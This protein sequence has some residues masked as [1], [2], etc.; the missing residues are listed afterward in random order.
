[1]KQNVLSPGNL[2][3]AEGVLSE[4]GYSTQLVKNY[5]RKEIKASKFR[6]KEW[7]YYLFYNQS[8]GIALTMADNSYLGL[9]S[10]TVLDFENQR[11]TTVSPMKLLTLGK[12]KFPSSSQEGDLHFQNNK[13]EI[14]FYHEENGRR[15]FL[16]LKDFEADQPLIVDVLLSNEPEDSM[17]IATPFSEDEKAFYYNQKIVGMKAQGVVIY[18]GN[19]MKFDSD[20]THAILDWGRG[21]W[22]YENT[23]YWSAATGSIDGHSFGF[24]LGYGFGNTENATENM[25]FYDGKAHKLEHVTFEIPNKDDGTEDYMKTWRFTSSDGRFEAVF[26]PILDRKSFTSLKIISSDQHQ[27]FGYFTGTA[28]LDDGTKVHLNDFLGFAEKV[29]NKW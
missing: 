16:N 4:A 17:V 20:T 28:I 6:I 22:T 26:N 14:N 12:M 11:E 29:K 24:N 8:F 5:D 2:L 7:D 3:T 13:I 10:A 9:L 27:V 23:W 18:K 25:L 19:E 21:V 1:M 15:L